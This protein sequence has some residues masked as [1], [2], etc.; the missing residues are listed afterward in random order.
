MVFLCK[1]KEI[2][3]CPVVKLPVAFDLLSVVAASLSFT[4]L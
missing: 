4:C 3:H 2:L 1:N